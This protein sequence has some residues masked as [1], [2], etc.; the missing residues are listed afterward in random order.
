MLHSYHTGC[1][2]HSMREGIAYHKM[3]GGSGGRKRSSKWDL[4]EESR[5]SFENKHS[6][7]SWSGKAAGTTYHETDGSN[8][9]RWSTVEPRRSSH[10]EDLVDDEFGRSSKTMGARE[11]D[12]G[13]GSSRRH[14]PNKEWKRPRRSRSRSRSPIRRESGTTDRGRSRSSQSSQIC[15]EFSAGKCRRGNHCHFLH[16]GG[17]SYEDSYDGRRKALPLRY[18]NDAEDYPSGSSGQSTG[19]VCSD[20]LKGYCRRG[21][22]CRL[23]H[24]DPSAKGPTTNELIRERDN[25]DRRTHRGSS[26]LD[27]HDE[28]QSRGRATETPCRYFAAGNCRKGRNCWFSHQGQQVNSSPENRRPRNERRLMEP[29]VDDNQDK[30]WDGLKWSDVDN[31]SKSSRDVEKPWN[32]EKYSNRVNPSDAAKPS[33]AGTTVKPWSLNNPHGRSLDGQTA[34]DHHQSPANIIEGGRNETLMVKGGNASDNR[35]FPEQSMNN[36]WAGDMEMSPEWNYGPSNHIDKGPPPP[37]TEVSAAIQPLRHDTSSIQHNYYSRDTNGAPREVNGLH[38]NSSGSILGAPSLNPSN[39]LS[40]NNLPALLPSMNSVEQNRVG[41]ARNPMSPTVMNIGGQGINNMQA[42][43]DRSAAAVNS[44]LNPNGPSVNALPPLLPSMNTVEQ[45]RLGSTQMNPMSPTLLNIGGQGINSLQA[46]GNRSGQAVNSSIPRTQNMVSD[47]R[48][49]E[50]TNSIAM[51]LAPQLFAAPS[52]NQVSVV[53]QIANPELSAKLD[54]AVIPQK[55]YDPISDSIEPENKEKST[56]DDEE[57][58]MAALNGSREEAP[59]L[60]PGAVSEVV[61][62]SSGKKAAKGASKVKESKP[63]EDDDDIDGDAKGDEGKKNKE[64]KGIRAFKFALVEFVKEA[65]KPSWKEGQVTKD[66]YKNIVKKVVEKVSGTVQASSIPQ[67]PE[68]IELYLSSSKPKLT[69]LVQAYVEKFQK[70]K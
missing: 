52:S 19:G 56:G 31:Y 29:I 13:Y 23:S 59:N 26:P 15:K 24:P 36:D 4:K 34:R 48:V 35:H 30:R 54:Q 45:S 55:Q 27:R 1:V 33:D 21:A 9:S 43:G 41:T 64:P 49:A 46:M 25:I 5:T 14:S 61:K 10:G 47:G 7:N 44:S 51:F 28:Q 67:T 6:D 40:M 32:G 65:L 11:R 22:S 12:E 53:A 20:F 38:T 57:A 17:E 3:S 18:S 66:S 39:G 70:G 63:E 68:K 69:K 37:S 42:M 62:E 60:K 16:E 2:Q 8:R 50:L 58:Q